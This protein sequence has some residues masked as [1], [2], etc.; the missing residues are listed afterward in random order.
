[1]S[2]TPECFLGIDVSKTSLD[3]H[4]RPQ[5]TVRRF[6][7]TPGGVAKLI[8]FVKPTAPTLIVLEATGGYENAA[9]AALSLAGLPVC[10]VNPK[11][12]RDFAGALGRLA[13]TDTIDACVLAEF[14]DKVRPPL[15]PLDDADTQKI[16]ALL[17]RRS[18]LIGMRTMESNRLAG[19][20]D[21]AIRRSIET[22]IRVLDKELDRADD[23]L[24]KA[25]QSSPVWKAKDERL[26]TI[27]GIGPVVSRTLLAEMPELGTLSREEAAA[28]AGVAPMNRDSGAWN[29][30]RTIRGGRSA[31]RSM[32]YLGSH[33]AKQG[34][35]V[36]QAFANRLQ[37]A[38][39][40]P[41]VIRIALARKLLIIANAVLRDECDWKPKMA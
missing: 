18:Q 40:A 9:V 5:G 31:V 27:P 30:R 15:R 7:N 6:D 1:M 32:L 2:N 17:T 37:A 13:K 20:T 41:K 28:L 12:V 36:L 34:N 3:V 11:R 22:M 35:A 21:R 33:A 25:I 19:V 4:L 10:L 8:E 14:A 29:G 23:D 38:G 24:D 39:K 26:Q 16:Q